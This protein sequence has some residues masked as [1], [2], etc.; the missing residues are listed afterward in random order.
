LITASG[1]GKFETVKLLVENKS[2]VDHANKKG[3]T[4]LFKASERGHTDI[5][6]FLID[7]GANVNVQ[8][9][10]T[11]RTPLMYAVLKR[12]QDTAKLL[13]EKGAD[14]NISDLQGITAWRIAQ[15]SRQPE[16][17][18]MLEAAGAK[19]PARK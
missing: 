10:V 1:V 7:K 16:M 8:T 18:K 5:V 12:R 9:N 3:E 14:P 11:K 2:I 6:A 13:L 15:V 4:A 17:M 19:P